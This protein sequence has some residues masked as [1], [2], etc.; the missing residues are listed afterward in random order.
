MQIERMTPFLL[1]VPFPKGRPLEASVTTLLAIELVVVELETECGLTGMGYTATIGLGARAIQAL[2]EEEAIRDLI[3]KQ[4]PFQTERF[5]D[6]IYWRTMFVGRAGIALMALSALDMALWDLKAKACQRP[7]WQLLGGYSNIVNAYGSG[8]YLSLSVDELVQE[9]TGFVETG[10]KAVKMKIGNKQPRQDLERVRAV[11]E[12]IGDE[13]ELYVDANQ[14]YDVKTAIEVA[15]LLAPCGVAWLEEPIP[16][17]DWPGHAAIREA[18]PMKLATGETLYT[19]EPFRDFISHRAVD[20]VQAD[21]S[22]LGGVTEWMKVAALAKAWNLP[23][24]P[25]FVLDIHLHLVAAISNGLCVEA[26]F[27]WISDVLGQPVRPVN[28]QYTLTGIPGTGLSISEEV[29]REYG[30]R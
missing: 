2:L 30:F 9:M 6:Q 23:M 16:A 24:A 10:F 29:K 18:I 11:R 25:H 22:R 14:V 19:L 21:A 8:G 28:G 17:G 13:I 20:V 27:P 12:A 1:R 7:L 26:I 3:L 15:R 5:W 4:D